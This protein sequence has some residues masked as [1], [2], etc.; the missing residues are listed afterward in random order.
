[1]KKTIIFLF[2][3]IAMAQNASAL[4]VSVTGHGDI[5]A[6]GM[7]L[8]ITEAKEDPMTEQMQMELKGSLLC[9]NTLTVIINRSETG[10][11]D[12]FC[13]AD[14]CIAGSGEKS[15][16]LYYTP[17][18]LAKW[19]AHYAP[20]ANSDVTVE[21]I[22]SDG[23]ES[24]TLSVHYVYQTEAIETVHTPTAKSGIYSIN[25]TLLDKDGNTDALPNGMYIQN[26]K[27]II[28]STH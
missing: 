9:S 11:D 20:V 13:C 3:A 6:E 16:T 4:L 27:K 19:F 15:D 14:Q 10:L 28:K 18:G 23:T 21:Y 2:A 17:G 1:M 7:E 22:F 12:E 25:G 24:R 5:P 26:G 8:T